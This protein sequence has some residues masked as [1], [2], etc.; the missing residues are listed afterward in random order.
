MF[1][2][3]VGRVDHGQVAAYFMFIVDVVGVVVTKG[4]HAV[5]VGEGLVPM[6]DGVAVRVDHLNQAVVAQKDHVAHLIAFGE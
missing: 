1:W 4:I 2:I 3:E 6:F 5:T